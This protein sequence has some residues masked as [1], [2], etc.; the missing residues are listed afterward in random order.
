MGVT[1]DPLPFDGAVSQVW[2]LG[3]GH[4]VLRAG[5]KPGML[6][7]SRDHGV[8]WQSCDSF[9]AYPD[10]D[11]WN[12]GAAGLVVHTIVHDP[13]VAERFW[14]GVSA[15]GVFATGDGGKTFERRNRLANAAACAHH[16]H[17]AA[18]ANGETGHCVHNMVR[19]PGDSELLYQQNHH[20]VW[21]SVDGG[22]S[23]QDIG[24]GLPSTFGFPIAVHPHDP[25]TIFTVP[26]NGD[27][28][29]RFPPDA[30]AAVWRSRNGGESWEAMRNGLPQVAC[31]FTVLRQAMATDTLG[32]AGLYFGTNSGS[33]FASF[34]CG[35]TWAAIAAHLPTIT[36]IET[37]VR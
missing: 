15:A 18:P 32:D 20:G 26:L 14:L 22:R 12:P 17:P 23:W 35:E 10:R 7:E 8:T 29:G 25:N 16:D 21:R 19:A 24:D 37:L 6:Y 4:G 34:D 30:A 13:H 36:S 2:S 27:M 33:I 5:C 3:F 28:A 9:N 1:N 31:Y 11:R